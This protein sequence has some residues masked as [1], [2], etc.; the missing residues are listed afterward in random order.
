MAAFPKI[1]KDITYG[2]KYGP[3]MTIE[4]Q[5]DANA[6]LER[7]VEHAML[8]GRNRHDAEKIER[9]NLGYWA[10]YY[11]PEA[12]ERVERL[13]NTQHPVFGK[14]AERGAPTPEQALSA[15]M[16]LARQNK[17]VR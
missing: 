16:E 2:D 11:N 5:E 10:G 4:T 3:A 15:G 7:L 8:F 6:Y 9:A 14:I 12:R 17:A 13:F 1:P